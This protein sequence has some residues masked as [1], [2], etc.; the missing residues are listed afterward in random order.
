MAI[1]HLQAADAVPAEAKDGA[2]KVRSW[3]LNT[4][5]RRAR[6]AAAVSGL[7]LNLFIATPHPPAY[8]AKQRR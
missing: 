8:E 1:A 7:R 4:A 3:R 5:L 2:A 6:D